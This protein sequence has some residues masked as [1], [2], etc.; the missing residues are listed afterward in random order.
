MRIRNVLAITWLGLLPLP[1]LSYAAET[2]KTLYA[3]RCQGCHGA[4][5]KGNQTMAK[6]LQTNIPDLTS[7]DVGKTSEKGMVEVISKGKGKM[8]PATGLSDKELK[9]LGAYV[10]GLSKGK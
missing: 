8:P 1:R 6:A 9:D 7:K 5:A 10:K 2:A 3:N 4:D